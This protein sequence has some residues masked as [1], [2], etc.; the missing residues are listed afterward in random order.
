MKTCV[1][2]LSLFVYI[3]TAMKM[4]IECY[5][6]C[7]WETDLGGLGIKK[8]MQQHVCSVSS[9]YIITKVSIL[10]EATTDGCS[11]LVKTV[12]LPALQS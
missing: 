2:M 3:F 7:K 11:E 4:T 8:K 5:H 12:I 10:S 1:N 9:M 6:V